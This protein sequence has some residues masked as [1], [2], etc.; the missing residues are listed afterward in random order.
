[1][2]LR[3]S[4]DTRASTSPPRADADLEQLY[5]A[6]RH[7]HAPSPEQCSRMAAHIDA[8]AA[9]PP[10]C[11]TQ[12]VGTGLLANRLVHRMR[13]MLRK[14]AGIGGIGG[15]GLMALGGWLYLHPAPTI[16]PASEQRPIVEAASPAADAEFEITSSAQ[17]ST[18]APNPELH[19]N[20]AP[21]ATTRNPLRAK[22]P[23]QAPAPLRKAPTPPE[24]QGPVLAQPASK[25]AALLHD[26]AILN[27]VETHLRRGRGKEALAILESETLLELEKHGKALRAAAQ[28]QSGDRD[29]G[30]WLL[31]Q[32]R[33]SNA[34]SAVFA[35]ASTYC[36]APLDAR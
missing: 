19:L 24:T 13:F 36:G 17:V 26:L 7:V 27:R 3:L 8:F 6:I 30:L 34:A 18:V 29:A 22:R 33:T 35:R 21:Q 5:T 23:A 20:A 12:P 2:T 10:V 1:V 16:P 15:A 28:C 14:F 11:A 32:E 4:A 9:L 31:R 25:D